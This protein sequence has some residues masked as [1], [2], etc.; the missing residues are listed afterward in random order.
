MLYFFPDS[1]DLVDPSFDFKKETRGI[2]RLRQRDDYYPHEIFD[3]PPY[4]GILISRAIVDER[5]TLAQKQRLLRLGAREF[6]RI[7]EKRLAHLKVMGDCGAFGYKAAEV[8]PF[9]VDDVIDFYERCGFD[10]GISV[11]HVILAFDAAFDGSREVPQAH[12]DRQ[13]LT[14]EYAADFFHKTHGQRTRF[15]PLG[16]AQGWSPKSYA[17]AVVALQK[18]GYSYI[19]MGGMVPM[20]TPDILA[21]LAAVKIIL[22]PRTRLH[23]LGVTRCENLSV[24]RDSGV[25]SFDSTA[26]LLQAFK[27][28]TDNYYT[29]SDP[30]VALRV[31]QVEGNPK[32]KAAIL[33]GNVRQETARQLE[34]E[35]LQLLTAFDRGE[36][37]IDEVLNSLIAYEEL[38]TGK[39]KRRDAYRRVLEAKPWQQCRCEVCSALGVHV[40]MFRGAERNRRRGFHNLQVFYRKVRRLT[41]EQRTA[42]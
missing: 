37:S 32:L 5:Y 41:D 7:G 33:S 26:A 13:T 14:L 42:A 18:M 19:A 25:V 2:S 28:D 29:D 35:C 34:R 38:N 10:F 27:S 31:P 20:K 3:R 23:L 39:T 36:S 1:Q 30:F 12:R 17:A 11:D 8:P 15:E 22:H 21:S 4:D 9:S 16:V 40:I 24:F 6:L